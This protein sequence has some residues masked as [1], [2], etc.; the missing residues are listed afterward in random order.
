MTLH[1]VCIGVGCTGISLS[2]H[3]HA[4]MYGRRDPSLGIR[5]TQTFDLETCSRVCNVVWS[6]GLSQLAYGIVCCL[7]TYLDLHLDSSGI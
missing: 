1:G 5:R 6:P 4:S 7:A 3:L 2:L